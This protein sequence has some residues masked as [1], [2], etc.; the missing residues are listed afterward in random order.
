MKIVNSRSNDKKPICVNCYANDNK[1]ICF[2]CGLLKRVAT[3]NNDGKPICNYCL[4]K[5]NSQLCYICNQIKIINNHI[6]NHKI[7]GNC[8]KLYIKFDKNLDL[9]KKY[10]KSKKILHHFVFEY[11]YKEYIKEYSVSR[12]IFENIL[13][14]NDNTLLRYD[15]YSKE[16]NLLVELNEPCHYS[17]ENYHK[18]FPNQTIDN[19]NKYCKNFETKVKLAKENN[20]ELLIIDVKYKMKWNELRKLYDEHVYASPLP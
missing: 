10:K 14:Y 15:Y 8:S 7:C 18:R 6:N 5:N 12:L 20:I 3:R 19:F 17:W 13:N 4:S 2:Q 16:R 9:I 1:L 11:Y